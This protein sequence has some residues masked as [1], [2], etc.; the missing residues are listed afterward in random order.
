MNLLQKFIK[1]GIVGMI[2]MC[3]DFGLTWFLKE[4]IRINKY[5]ANAC[6]FSLAVVNN[7][8]LNRF[9]TFHS[10]SKNWGAELGLFVLFSLIGLLLNT[11]FIGLFNGKFQIPFYLAKLMAT[12]LVFI[13]NFTSNNY[14]NF[15]H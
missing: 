6:G 4:K 13:W 15:H 10:N 7:Y 8:L 9:W 3:I 12:G 1:F 2:G 5:V 11:L 14:F